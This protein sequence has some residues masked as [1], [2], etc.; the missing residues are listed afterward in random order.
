MLLEELCLFLTV[1]A[2]GLSGAVL[3]LVSKMRTQVGHHLER[4]SQEI[5]RTAGTLGSLQDE[6]GEHSRREY[7]DWSI[8]RQADI[9]VNSRL[10][11]L[12][13]AHAQIAKNV[14]EH[15][16]T[17]HSVETA[18]RQ[19]SLD[20]NNAETEIL[21]KLLKLTLDHA[22]D[23]EKWESHAE[24][25]EA[26]VTPWQNGVTADIITIAASITKISADVAEGQ[27]ENHISHGQAEDGLAELHFTTKVIEE[28]VRSLIPTTLP[29]EMVPDQWLLGDREKPAALI[30]RIDEIQVDKPWS[31]RTGLPEKFKFPDAATARLTEMI[32]SLPGVESAASNLHPL[33]V[34]YSSETATG[35]QTGSLE[36]VQTM[37]GRWLPLARDGET[38]QITEI[39][40]LVSNINPVAV[41]NIGWQIA[42]MVTAQKH[43]AR[44]HDQLARLDR[45]LSR[46]SD[47]ISS[48][49][50]GTLN[51]NYRYLNQLGEIL[52]NGFASRADLLAYNIKIEDIEQDSISIFE[53]SRHRIAK[54]LQAVSEIGKAE[55]NDRGTPRFYEPLVRWAK[56]Q[57]N[58][59][60]ETY[61]KD[62]EVDPFGA[63][64]TAFEEDAHLM[65]NALHV[66]LL[67][68]QTKHLMPTHEGISITRLNDVTEMHQEIEA[69]SSAFLDA[70][71]QIAPEEAWWSKWIPRL[72]VFKKRRR[73]QGMQDYQCLVQKTIRQSLKNLNFNRTSLM[74]VIASPSEVI[75][76]D[77]VYDSDAREI[78]HVGLT[79]VASSPL[80]LQRCPD[81]REC[82]IWWMLSKKRKK[83]PSRIRKPL[84]SLGIFVYQFFNEEGVPSQFT[85]SAIQ[86]WRLRIPK[87]GASQR[88]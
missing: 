81:L 84:K 85:M 37:D 3:W 51:G 72:F 26:G 9:D 53:A 1:L 13:I 12:T 44:I 20:R 57:G 14:Y 27:R 33:R 24:S 30:S 50:V 78:V 58:S 11:D 42:T 22:S 43:L 41:L 36:H 2:L 66:R 77:C 62:V 75:S 23:R 64:L 21:T 73:Y 80:K 71:G 18:L 28:Q 76:L 69:L 55:T 5:A 32:R 82:R 67:A 59:L 56:E 63:T 65:V 8:R 86:W 25:V 35:L 54:T 29:P 16:T 17:I 39:G 87:P 10:N 61:R 88:L 52:T 70:L 47:L 49:A 7:E 83:R 45:Q 4:V 6:Q 74:E 34:V 19:H 48:Q 46:L 31:S 15:T 38:K 60:N 40:H 79:D 68:L